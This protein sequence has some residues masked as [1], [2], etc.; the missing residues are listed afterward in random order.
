MVV[1]HG[2]GSRETWLSTFFTVGEAYIFRLKN[3]ILIIDAAEA[4]AGESFSHCKVSA[5]LYNQNYK[6]KEVENFSRS[7]NL[8]SDT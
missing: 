2:V 3:P 5:L 6:M 7:I 8:F 1:Q 4:R